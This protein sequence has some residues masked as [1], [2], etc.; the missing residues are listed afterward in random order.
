MKV[1]SAL[2]LALVGLVALA[3]REPV[4]VLPGGKLDGEL[5]PAGD[6]FA[7]ADGFATAQLETRPEDPYSVN[8]TY[9]VVDGRSYVNAGGSESNWAKNV[10]A[11]PRVRLRVDGALHELVAV[12]VTDRAEIASFGKAWLAQSS[13]RRD[14][15]SFDEVWLYRL[16]PR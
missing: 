9:T 7:P 16:E 5:R 2:W 15:L 11:D 14:P 1:R 12:R 6:R 4:L 13:T 8:I 10:S 3:C